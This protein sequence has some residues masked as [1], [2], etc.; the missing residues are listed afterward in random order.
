MAVEKLENPAKPQLLKILV[1]LLIVRLSE[2]A[3]ASQP[4]YHLLLI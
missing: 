1:E 2:P 4:G 3:P